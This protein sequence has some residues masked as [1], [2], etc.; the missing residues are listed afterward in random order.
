MKILLVEDNAQ[1]SKALTALLKRSSHLVDA[2]FDGE[3]ALLY[4]R[5][6]AYDVI[7]LDI[8]M[9]KIDGLEVLR[10]LR[11]A[12]NDTPVLLL[13]AK[14]TV[15]DKIEGLDSGA[16]DYLAK[17]FSTEEL[18]ARIRALGRRK[19]KPMKSEAVSFG[20]FR[21]DEG[22]CALL[23]GGESVALSNKEM[24]ILR[25]LIEANGKLVSQEQISKS[26][27]ESD[28]FSTNEN[29]WVHISNLRKKLQSI[30][31]KAKIKS[32]RYQGYYLEG[33]EA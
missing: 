28:A 17:P 8:M 16:D 24:V 15:D 7:V 32:I 13:T 31:A 11:K 4:L 1:L 9:P 22:A 10:R 27:W 25:L 29:V 14:S 30:G 5:D 6:F 26:A 19:E 3:E 20:D 18:L 33:G 23:R 12:G 21:L 2:A